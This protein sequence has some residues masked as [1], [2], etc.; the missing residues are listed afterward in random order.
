MMKYRIVGSDVGNR[1]YRVAIIVAAGERDARDE[2]KRRYPD[3]Y[4]DS[5][6]LLAVDVARGLCDE[7]GN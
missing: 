5:A 6:N 4:I 7:N 3:G 1:A 2:F